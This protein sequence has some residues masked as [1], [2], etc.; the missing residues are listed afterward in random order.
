MNWRNQLIKDLAREAPHCMR[1]EKHNEGQVVAAHSNQSRDGKGMS[2]KAHDFRIAYLDDVC[3]MEID[4]GKGM[5][6]E[7]RIEAWEEAHRKTIGWL[8]EAGHLKVVA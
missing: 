6:R 8:F 4:Q 3:H 5:T 7:E 1:C 2:I